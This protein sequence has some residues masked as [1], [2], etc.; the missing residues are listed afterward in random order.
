[1]S[2]LISAAVVPLVLLA[3]VFPCAAQTGPT[4]EVHRAVLG[5]AYPL[6][7]SLAGAELRWRAELDVPGDAEP[8]W[9]LGWQ[10][11]P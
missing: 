11:R 1:M 2:P 5:D 8:R 9:S 3:A 6:D 7:A 4:A 10:R